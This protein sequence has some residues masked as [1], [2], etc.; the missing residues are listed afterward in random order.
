MR[1][2]AWH[3]K[4]WQSARK[5]HLQAA[6]MFLIQT[7]NVISALPLRI[8]INIF[9]L[10]CRSC[11]PQHIMQ[12]QAVSCTL[13]FTAHRK[14]VLSVPL[15]HARHISRPSCGA[16]L[17]KCGQRKKMLLWEGFLLSS[18]LYPAICKEAA[19][20]WAPKTTHLTGGVGS[21]CPPAQPGGWQGG[22]RAAVGQSQ[23]PSHTCL[24]NQGTQSAT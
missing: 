5:I 1:C 18:N 2:T 9:C 6:I 23:C 21:H 16:L 11:S 7:V 8:S 13:G 12:A 14:R 19:A 22:S 24:Q 20:L 17:H 4:L 15:T 10:C 3:W